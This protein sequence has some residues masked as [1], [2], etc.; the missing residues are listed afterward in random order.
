MTSSSPAPRNRTLRLTDAERS[1]YRQRL[2]HLDESASV[3]ALL[4]R[5]ICQDLFGALPRL[6]SQ[7][8]D[9]LILDPPYNLT[10]RFRHHL[11]RRQSLTQYQD[12]VLSWL[13]PLSHTLKPDA[14][15]YLCG[16]WQSSP[17]LYAAAAEHFTI[18]SRIT[19]EREKGRGARRNW[20]NTAE[21]IWFCTQSA[22][23]YF[24]ADAVRVMRRV[25]APYTDNQGN[26]KDWHHTPRGKFRLTAPSNLWTDITVPFWSMPENTEHPT[27]KPEKLIAKLILASTFPGAVV[28]DPFLGSGTT[29]VVAKKLDRQFVGIEL[30]EYYACL[31]EKRL[32]QATSDRR[33]QGY[34]DRIFWER[35]SQPSNTS[36]S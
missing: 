22:D 7:W 3:A 35:N 2:L 27:Q 36:K 18:R 34:S 12:W 8:V 19:W 21:D 24:D 4:N 25:T 26:P 13:T 33:I 15:I 20:K 29:S 6:P 31:A 28:L 32:E 9:L 30:D 16:D 5:T 23:Y 14:S 17:A 1:R 11:T 10:K